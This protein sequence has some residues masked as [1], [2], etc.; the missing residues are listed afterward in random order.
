MFSLNNLHSKTFLNNFQYPAI[1]PFYSNIDTTDANV[2]SSI[3]YFK[4]YDPEILN[5]ASN[6]V[7]LAFDGAY[8]FQATFVFVATWANVGHYQA[9]N[10]VGNT[11]QVGFDI[12]FFRKQLQ[13]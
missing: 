1:A 6:Y 13:F 7:K 4:S 10:D 8:D 3:S 11:F 5:K 2:T 12:K 9:K